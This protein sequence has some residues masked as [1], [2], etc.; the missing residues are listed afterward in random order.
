MKQ[1]KRALF[2]AVALC[3]ML[4]L[5]PTMAFAAEQSSCTVTFKVDGSVYEEE[6]VELT[7]DSDGFTSGTVTKPKD[8]TKASDA[9][10]YEFSGWKTEEGT[11]FFKGSDSGAV[12]RDLTLNAAWVE[13]LAEGYELVLSSNTVS[14][15]YKTPI[16]Q[17]PGYDAG[18][19][20]RKIE[21]K[22]T[23][24]AET[25][26]TV[27][28]IGD[29]PYND[30]Q[31]AVNAAGNNDTI[32]L[33]DNV[34]LSDR[35]FINAGKDPAYG[36][37]NNRYAT[38]SADN[39][40][41]LN[42]NG[43]NITSSSNLALAGGSLTITGTGTIRTTAPGLAPVEI[44][45]TGA[46]NAKRTLNIDENV[47]LH[48]T[49]YGLNV[50]GSNSTDKNTIDVTVNGRVEGMLFVLGNL[51]NTSNEINIV[52]NGTVDA[53]SASGEENV[54]TGIAANGYAD[55]TV[56]NGATVKG[57]SGIEIRAGSLT[58]NG[59]TITAT[60]NSYSY[61]AS[62]NGT[63]TKG[64]AIAVAQYNA[65]LPV[66][67][68]LKG[69]T[70]T[71]IKKIGV[72]DVNGDMTNVNVT[73]AGTIADGSAVPDGYM[74]ADGES[75][76]TKVLAKIVAKIGSTSYA[77]LNSAF[78]AAQSGNTIEL[79]DNVTLT[80]RLFINAGENPSYGGTNS[81]YATTS[82][83][84]SITL[85][86]NGHNITSSSNLALAGGSLTITGTGTIST[87]APGLAPVEIRG[88]GDLNAKRTLTIGKNVTLQGQCY[89]LNVFGSNDAQKNMIDVNVNEGA[90]VEGTLF[91]LG[92]LKNTSNE[93]NIVVNGTVN[94]LD[95]DPNKPNVGIALNGYANVT[96]N[97]GA[98]VRGESGIEIRAGRLTVNGG[99]I[100]ATGA[101]LQGNANNSGSTVIG[102]AVAVSQHSTDLAT[103]VT[104][105][106]GS[107]TGD[108]AFYE[109]DLQNNTGHDN[110]SL[111]VTDGTFNGNVS[112][113][114]CTGFITGG[115]FSTDPSDCLSKSY[116]AVNS[117]G[118]WTV[119]AHT[120]SYDYNPSTKQPD[121]IWRRINGEWAAVAT[122]T[123]VKG[124]E[125]Q[126]VLA[127]ITSETENSTITYT[128]KVTFQNKEYTCPERKTETASYTVTFG[129]SSNNYSWGQLCTLT[130]G[131]GNTNRKW[132]INGRL[133]ADGR[134]SY[135]FAVTE[136]SNVT[137]ADTEAS[138]P[139]AVANVT[140]TSTTS[141]QAVYNVKWSLPTDAQNVT[142][143]IYRGAKSNNVFA[144]RAL[145]ESKGI[146]IDT[147]LNVR[148]GDFTLKISNLTSTKY[149]NVI[150]V[151]TYESGG[152]KW[153]LVTP[154]FHIQANGTS[155]NGTSD[156]N[157]YTN[158]Q[159]NS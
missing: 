55:V 129:T 73:V 37:S 124:D 133:V 61:A 24:V 121:W 45:G 62:G 99:T 7:Q 70:L 96:V 113:Q 72:T 33:H 26:N 39:S 19:S 54:H 128:A 139:I 86:L 102:A 76:G 109:K 91:V 17:I 44:R 156:G 75:S 89:G 95:S 150:T 112:S 10:R 143:M 13:Y 110:I 116:D 78:A 87:T 151:I 46:L 8:P 117:N 157:N 3:M 122:F 68:D 16:S 127:T 138:E 154:V 82:A 130:D 6:T 38:T 147:G 50:F 90:T 105:H 56:N 47:T 81:R 79:Q 140:L 153:E 118:T 69:G 158:T 9:K 74:W 57:D 2:I 31:T 71:G 141:D 103:S 80:E 58:V 146:R 145:L 63:T 66:T 111:R 131:D 108:Y 159:I 29:T 100:T 148:N 42:L 98:T 94:A 123:C 134:G 49:C 144:S 28:K 60:A 11:D 106:G 119:K 155:P 25:G 93:I 125:T 120:H 21:K 40:I 27:A 36:G 149:Q 67:A 53:S 34:S 12:N 4:S 35:L 83:D 126:K 132:Y 18:A 41:T 14:Q 97:E 77:N 88:T 101:S 23:K 65:T 92:N 52:V 64:A 136:T 48:G 115:T 85:N 22:R 142:A 135:T 104:I 114:N 15:D 84:N 30:L 43:H 20:I 32:V 152:Q 51:K 107:F 5:L 59:G 137:T 1:F